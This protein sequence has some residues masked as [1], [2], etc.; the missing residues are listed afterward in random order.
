MGRPKALVVVDGEPLVRRGRRVLR[1]AGLAPRVVVL[2]AGHEEAAAAL[3]DDPEAAETVVVAD[4]WDEGMGASLRAGLEA[5]RTTSADEVDAVVVTLVDTPGIG[6]A[7][8]R[9]VAERGG[10]QALARGAFDGV[11]GHPVLLGRAHWDAVTDTAH[12]DAGA[13][14]YLRGH[15]GLTL[16]EV[17]D[18]AD[19][20]DVDTPADLDHLRGA[21]PLH[22]PRD[23]R[24]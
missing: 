17:G 20:A 24:S 12:G 2:G 16:V 1:D 18:V 15:P 7:A 13:R 11:P 23:G 19:P 9:R 8:V 22:H 4:G 10:T 3:G 21:H 14:G 6:A 5:L